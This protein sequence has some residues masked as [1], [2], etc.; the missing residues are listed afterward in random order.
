MLAKSLVRRA[1]RRKTVTRSFRISEAAFDALEEDAIRHN[2]SLNTLVDQIFEAHASYERFIEKL[3]MMRMAKS[4][5]HRLL[6]TASAEGV[7]QAAMVH[8]KDQGRAAAIS[9]YGELN[10]T[11]ILDGLSLM[12]KYGGWAEY[13]ETESGRGK[14]VITL[15]H[16]L[17]LN[18]SIYLENFVKF[19]FQEIALAPKITTTEHSV[20]IDI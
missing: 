18:G 4:T 11:N 12:C 3:G 5:F 16:N 19:I 13:H 7:A 15:M 8:A 14:R 2:V 10:L 1:K 20:V 9:K 6:E 17:G